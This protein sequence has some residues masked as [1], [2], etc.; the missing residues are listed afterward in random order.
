MLNMLFEDVL[1][2]ADAH[3]VTEL[4]LWL[5][6][7]ALLVAMLAARSG[8]ATRFASYAPTLLTSLGILGTFVGIV[9]GLMDFNPQNI[10]GSIQ[11]LLEGLKTA[12]TTSLAG[13]GGAIIFR[14]LAST[15]LLSPPRR[16]EFETS[17]AGPEEILKALNLHSV[18]LD[19]L[20]ATIGG[21]EEA[22]LVGQLKLLRSDI[23][24]QH[25]ETRREAEADKE[26]F[27]AFRNDLSQ[28]LTT[29]TERLSM[30]QTSI[31]GD[32]DSSLAGQLKLLRTDYGDQHRETLKEIARDREILDGLATHLWK[33][34]D[35]FAQMLSKSATEQVINAL[36]EVIADFNKHLTEQFGENF[37][38]LNIAVERLLQ[39]QENYKTQLGEMSDQYAQGVQA[40]TQTET[41]IAHISVESK[42]IPLTM[43]ELKAVLEV[44][45]HQLAELQN[46]LTAFRDIRDR[47]VQAVP[48]IRS[49]IQSTMDAVETSV[50]TASTHYQR[51]LDSS[52]TYVKTHDNKTNELL[53]KFT[54]ITEQK[55][56]QFE[57]ELEKSGHSIQQVIETAVS[58]ASKHYA[59]LLDQSDIYIKAHD[60]QTHDLLGRFVTTT[61]QQLHQF[62]K[63]MV[64]SGASV[65]KIVENAVE[66]ASDHYRKLLD[67][68]DAHIKANEK[69]SQE[70][71]DRFTNTTT[72][73]IERVKDGLEHGVNSVK[74]AIIT[75]AEEFDNSVQRV[76]SNLTSTS[77]ILAQQSQ[78]VREQ[79][80]DSIKDI[81]DHMRLM[82]SDV[83]NETRDLTNTIKEAGKQ[84]EQNAQRIQR[85]FADSI[86]SMQSRLESV[87][88]ELFAA[89][90]RAMNSAVE[91]ILK[92][93]GKAVSTTGEGVNKQLSAID[94]SMQKEINRVMNEMGGALAQIAG[95]FTKDYKNLVK[96]MADV[97]RHRQALEQ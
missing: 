44:N 94:E 11:G 25:R 13:M 86:Q 42:Q 18:M 45:Q 43:G 41:S 9:V 4:F 46:H 30:L 71:F 32:E 63:S 8:K 14:I 57:Q 84:T 55:L 7:G 62:E 73:S 50:Q 87:T 39:W 70:L 85:E 81:N 53:D 15:P 10:D 1:R 77:D 47:A 21:S 26:T 38:A 76:H 51:L 31:S 92:E 67:V 82:I 60:K 91:G 29:Q 2:N 12:F 56:H 16:I 59:G 48:E 28:M 95:Q 68:S 69:K 65:Q 24:D 66:G 17:N 89:Q 37:K 61:E 58:L 80:K 6:L 75:G 72:E 93:M 79:L 83:S 90:T 23:G 64:D 78:E 36:K 88:Q 40:I 20:H 27:K 52:D 5:L 96:A 3:N 35:E 49:Q 19:R 33:Q 74:T 34:L 97:I 54:K 22:S